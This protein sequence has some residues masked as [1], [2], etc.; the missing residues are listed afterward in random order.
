MCLLIEINLIIINFEVLKNYFK[1][2][3]IMVNEINIMLTALSKPFSKPIDGGIDFP[4]NG[5]CR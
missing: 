4:L 2:I 3:E 5:V 1:Q